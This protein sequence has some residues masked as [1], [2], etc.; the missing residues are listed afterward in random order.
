M[1]M[2][3]FL[4]DAPLTAAMDADSG[5]RHYTV[6]TIDDDPNVCQALKR[7][8]ERLNLE[9]IQACY[10]MH[11]IHLAKTVVPDLIITDLRMPQ[12]E[13]HN[14]VEWL[15][16]CPQTRHIP[17]VVLTGLQDPGLEERLRALGAAEYLSKPVSFEDLCDVLSRFLPLG[18]AGERT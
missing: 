7:R 17:V 14:V 13:G 4:D 2:I 18:A 9:V 3:Q 15:K 16:S 5:P 12:G 11:G 6:L 1:A 8:L 10:G